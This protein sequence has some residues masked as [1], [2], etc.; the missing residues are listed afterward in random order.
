MMRKL[1]L[2][3]ETILAKLGGNP[4]ISIDAL[5]SSP[6]IIYL[7]GFFLIILVVLLLILWIILILVPL[8]YLELQGNNIFKTSVP[9]NYFDNNSNNIYY[10]KGLSS[11]SLV[12]YSNPNKRPLPF[13]TSEVPN[14]PKKLKT[15]SEILNSWPGPTT[16]KGRAVTADAVIRADWNK[17]LSLISKVR[18][19]FDQ[20]ASGAEYDMNT[21]QFKLIRKEGVRVQEFEL[22]AQKLEELMAGV[23]RWAV[24]MAHKVNHQQEVDKDYYV[25]TGRMIN[26]PEKYYELYVVLDQFKDPYWFFRL[27]PRI[28][29]LRW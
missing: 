9:F 14:P 25:R 6:K 7:F 13:S 11:D 24:H 28:E 2:Y 29:Q 22:L 8:S 3:L 17:T 27:D 21:K 18:T 10:C 1:Y 16:F 4:N 20:I 19:L 12:P 26:S 23:S 15:L 5:F